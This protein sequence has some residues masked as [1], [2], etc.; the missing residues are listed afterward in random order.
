MLFETLLSMQAQTSAQVGES[1]E[2]K[3]LRLA[4]DIFLNTPDELNYEQTAKLIGLHR[5]PLE[6][7]LLQ[8]IERYNVLLRRMKTY[9]R[10]LQKGIKGLVVMSTELE[11]IYHAVNEGRVPAVWL[12]GEQLI[13][14]NQGWPA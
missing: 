13:T 3:V 5:S 8:E 1:T 12:K 4:N 6:V 9:L 11:D 2:A 7:V 10:D 14:L